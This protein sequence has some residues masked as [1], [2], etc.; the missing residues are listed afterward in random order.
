MKMEELQKKREQTNEHNKKKL[1]GKLTEKKSS[2]TFTFQSAK[3]EI[4]T[5]RIF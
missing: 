5:L 3:H 1:H 4:G 2:A